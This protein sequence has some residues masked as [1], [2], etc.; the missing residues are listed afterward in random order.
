[1]RS[2]LFDAETGDVIPNIRTRPYLVTL[3]TTRKYPKVRSAAI[4]VEAESQEA[5]EHYAQNTLCRQLPQMRVDSV[6]PVG[7]G[8]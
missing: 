2:N 6:W 5:A 1:M 4:E 8:R 3:V 7:P